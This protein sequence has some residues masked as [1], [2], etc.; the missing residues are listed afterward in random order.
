M[1][2]YASC[3]LRKSLI[4]RMFEVKNNRTDFDEIRYEGYDIEA[5][6]MGRVVVLV[7]RIREVT[8]YRIT[9]ISVPPGKFW[10]SP[11]CSVYFPGPVFYVSTLW[12]L[13]C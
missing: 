4:K 10:D 2:H 9:S 8:Q 13:G 3:L 1:T 11:P 7:G 12:T 5:N 6:M